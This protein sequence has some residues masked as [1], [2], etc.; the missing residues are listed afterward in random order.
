MHVY[1]TLFLLSLPD[2]SVLV[3]YRSRVEKRAGGT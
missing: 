1:G 3:F 2:V